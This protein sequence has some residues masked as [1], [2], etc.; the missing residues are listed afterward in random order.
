MS[1]RYLLDTNV[2]IDLLENEEAV[3]TML[4]EAEEAFVSSIAIGELFYGAEKS[5][6]PAENVS[7][8]DEF[9]AIT[10]VLGCDIQTARHYGQIKNILRARGRPIPE[11]DIWIAAVARQYALTLVTRDK[12]FSEIEDLPTVCW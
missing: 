1:G 3:R 11:N 4:G 5:T 8:I 12:H 2:I 7:R 9:A 10:R 6:H